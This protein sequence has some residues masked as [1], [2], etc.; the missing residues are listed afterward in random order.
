[1]R[2]LSANVKWILIVSGALTCTKFYAAVAPAEALKS[3]FGESLTG[4]I[5]EIVVRN[6]GALIGLVGVMLIWAAFVP[7]YRTMAISVA[8]A[9]KLVFIG[10]VL[11]LGREFMDHQAGVAVI[12]DS[13]M[14]V[15]YA[16]CLVALRNSERPSKSS[17]LS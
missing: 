3:T 2:W 13:I 4:P 11:S 8:A 6:W 5:A 14:V 1:M 12:A 9:S 15:V 17:R 7:M 16:L 10:L